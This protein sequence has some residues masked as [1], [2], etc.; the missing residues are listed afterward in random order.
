M[1][2]QTSFYNDFVFSGGRVKRGAFVEDR[3]GNAMLDDIRANGYAAHRKYGTWLLDD[4]L[5][6]PMVGHVNG[7]GFMTQA[8]K[9]KCCTA[10]RRLR[11]ASVKCR[12]SVAGSNLCRTNGT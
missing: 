2:L 7:R 4:G 6:E 8:E 3:L 1:H 10:P 12:L 9:E 11:D 5:S